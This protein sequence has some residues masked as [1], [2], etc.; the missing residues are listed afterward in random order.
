LIIFYFSTRA[1]R[2]EFIEDSKSKR[3]YCDLL[4]GKSNDDSSGSVREAELKLERVNLL[5]GV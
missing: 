4:E 2:Q 5:E 1:T 3:K